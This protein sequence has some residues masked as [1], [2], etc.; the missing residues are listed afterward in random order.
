MLIFTGTFALVKMK[1]SVEGIT[2]RRLK[3]KEG[4]N[5]ISLPEAQSGERT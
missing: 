5:V 3:G 4:F 1:C 2:F